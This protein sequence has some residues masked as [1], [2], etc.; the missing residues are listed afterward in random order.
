MARRQIRRGVFETN[1]SSVHSITII[2]DTIDS[3]KMAINDDGL[4]EVDAGEFGWGVERHRD[5]YTKLSYLVM[6][7]LETEGSECETVEQFYE[8]E[9][10]QKI[11]SEIASYCAC[12][13]VTVPGLKIEKHSYKDSKNEDRFY[14]DHDGYIDHQ[15]C[16]DYGS[17]QEFLDSNNVGVIEF[18]FNSSL[19]LEISNDNM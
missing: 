5:Q 16:E 8:T 17:L 12:K 6:M 3:N 19:I 1:S 10:F 9:G 7:A 14:I 18:V 15:S 11:N 4:I 2:K 13:G